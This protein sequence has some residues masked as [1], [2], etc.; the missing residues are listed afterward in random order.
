INCWRKC[1]VMG[2][3]SHMWWDCPLVN[4]FWKQIGIEILGRKVGISKLMVLISLSSTE[5]KTKEECKWV[6]WMVTAARQ[7]IASN[8]KNV[9][10]LG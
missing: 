10:V 9:E 8:W 1:G 6:K 3:Y 7:V 2:T 5:F 4:E